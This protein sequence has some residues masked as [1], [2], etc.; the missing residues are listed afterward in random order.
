MTQEEIIN[1]LTDLIL[2][3][4]KEDV[5]TIIKCMSTLKINYDF[6]P[7]RNIITNFISKTIK[8]YIENTNESL[9]VQRKGDYGIIYTDVY[10]IKDSTVYRNGHDIKW[11]AL[12]KIYQAYKQIIN[13]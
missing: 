11:S 4:Q 5:C 3:I 8:E 2:A 10:T 6:S 13:K 1:E 7:L 12:N 9:R